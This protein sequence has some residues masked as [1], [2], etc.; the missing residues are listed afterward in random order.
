MAA[1]TL[2]AQQGWW[3]RLCEH[4]LERVPPADAAALGAAAAALTAAGRGSDAEA[5]LRLTDDKAARS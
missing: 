2:M 4:C 1:V 5:V 3:P